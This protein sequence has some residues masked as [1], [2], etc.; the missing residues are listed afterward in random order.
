VILFVFRSYS[1]FRTALWH[2]QLTVT[3]PS[4]V[5]L[6]ILFNYI[7]KN[8]NFSPLKPSSPTLQKHKV[9]EMLLF[10]RNAHKYRLF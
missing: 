7:R 8:N 1:K 3:G 6:S 5:I 9:W 10:V 2:A 4:P